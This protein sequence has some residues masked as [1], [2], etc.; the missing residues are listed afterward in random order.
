MP[1]L[2]LDDAAHGELDAKL[3]AL[4]ERLVAS[5]PVAFSALKDEVD[6]LLDGLEGALLQPGWKSAW[7]WNKTIRSG[8]FLNRPKAPGPISE[9]VLESLYSACSELV[10]FSLDATSPH[11]QQSYPHRLQDAL[12]DYLSLRGHGLPMPPDR[13]TPTSKIDKVDHAI[14]ILMAQLAA[15]QPVNVKQIAQEVGIRRSTLYGKAKFQKILDGARAQ[16][17]ESKRTLSGRR[18]GDRDFQ[19]FQDAER[20]DRDD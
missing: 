6:R 4:L 17:Q 13:S 19:R 16:Q 8:W 14:A 20:G 2:K 15:N 7:L 12:S 11:R 3:W 18:V 5:P 1:L 9:E 10:R